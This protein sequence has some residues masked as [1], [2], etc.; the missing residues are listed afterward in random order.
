VSGLPAEEGADGDGLSGALELTLVWGA[1]IAFVFARRVAGRAMA[2]AAVRKKR[3]VKMD[4][5]LRRVPAVA[6]HVPRRAVLM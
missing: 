6:F 4:S 5:A 2:R 1:G 3:G